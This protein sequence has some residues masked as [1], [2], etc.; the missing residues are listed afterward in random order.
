[1]YWLCT[2][3]HG[4]WFRLRMEEKV[5]KGGGL[6]SGPEWKLEV[7]QAKKKAEGVTGHK[8]HRGDDTEVELPLQRVS[9]TGIILLHTEGE[10]RMGPESGNQF[11]EGC[12]HI[13]K[14]RL[15]KFIENPL[16]LFLI[17]IERMFKLRFRNIKW[18]SKVI[19]L[20]NYRTGIQTCILFPKSWHKSNF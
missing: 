20:I 4:T 12:L 15:S 19:Q 13:Y 7:T 3:Y 11:V 10:Q 2:G 17:L 9:V 5:P 8:E 1:M 16:P 14:Q 18:L 6:R